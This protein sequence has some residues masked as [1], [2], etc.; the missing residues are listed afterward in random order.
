M[1]RTLAIRD[2]LIRSDVNITLMALQL[3]MVSACNNDQTSL[4]W[5]PGFYREVYKM[6]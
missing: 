3:E 1:N 2:N 5:L 6:M 4:L